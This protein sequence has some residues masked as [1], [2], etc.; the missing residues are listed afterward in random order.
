MIQRRWR[1][2]VGSAAY[3]DVHPRYNS[4]F[5]DVQEL[6]D[7]QMF[8]R[9][10]LAGELTFQ[11]AD[12]DLI[13][14]ASFETEFLCVLQELV[15]G[16]WVSVPV[17]GK[18][19]KTDFTLIDTDNKIISVTLT[20]F[21]EYEPVLN[22][23]DFEYDL[24]TL[25]PP[26]VD[27]NFVIQ[28]VF[29]VVALQPNGSGV[30]NNFLGGVFFESTLIDTPTAGNLT[31]DYSFGLVGLYGVMMGVGEGIDPDISGEYVDEDNTPGDR[32]WRRKDGLY[33][34]QIELIGPDFRNIVK[35]VSDNVTV[36]EGTLNDGFDDAVF[37]STT[38]SDT[39]VF[40]NFSIYARLLMRS[41]TV[42]GDPTGVIDIPDPD[43]VSDHGNYTK[44]I[45][46]GNSD[47]ATYGTPWQDVISVSDNHS[48]TAERWGKFASD[49]F[50]FANEYFVS[51]TNDNQ[52]ST[53]PISRSEWQQAS[54]WWNYDDVLR[55]F[56]ESAAL[57]VTVVGYKLSDVI[58][59]LL[60]AIG[61][62]CDHQDDST[63]SDFLYSVSNTIRT[64]RMVPVITPKSNV[65]VGQ[66]DQPAQ[67]AP[68]RL[69][70]VLELTKWFYNAYWYIFESRF[71]IEHRHF[72]DNGLSYGGA[73]VG[74]DL[75]ALL[76]PRTGL[77]WGYRTSK[78][79]YEKERLPN[80]IESKWMDDVSRPFEGYP[81]Q[82]NSVY[83]NKGSV[84]QRQI[85]KFTSDIDFFN[86][87][88]SDISTS[89]F[90]FF[91]C[92]EDGADL[93]VPFLEITLSA[94][95]TYK[96]QNGYAAFVFAHENYHRHGLPAPDVTL[97]RVDITAT[98]T[99]RSK[100]QEIV[101]S[102]SD[103]IN[104]YELIETNLGQGRAKKIDQNLSGKDYKITIMHDTQ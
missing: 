24:I 61:A 36:Y 72:F 53:Y 14:A 34:I 83:V 9:R 82:V 30:L 41:D 102:L 99:I 74:A 56:Q 3:V 37:T 84:E 79:R 43:I 97:N 29:Q 23:M 98:T 31:I 75:T 68:I 52:D 103:E 65:L 78:Y 49:S 60:T 12:F 48:T 46:I 66:Y 5:S 85:T 8:F 101:I 95:E 59:S 57:A 47:P 62:T 58:N 80:R 17:V 4:S 18:F 7:E 27:V 42:A 1:L 21:D 89:G 63:Y 38:S 32:K 45:G 67:K 70:E 28:P 25:A 87:A 64:D 94:D 10:K 50:L 81:I 86:V 26:T 73:N 6:Q 91:D 96:L 35:R 15:G 2:K 19:Y 33:R 44:V 16:T 40:R 39:T 77:T 11:R 93:N 104:P 100:V 22:G 71:I 92:M 13:H 76:E 55:T 90:V 88:A 69:R 54:C 20:T 51:P